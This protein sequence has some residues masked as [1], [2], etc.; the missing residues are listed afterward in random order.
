M[1]MLFKVCLLAAVCAPGWV[2]ADEPSLDPKSFA[3]IEAI[4]EH[5]AR[6]DPAS[7][8]RYKEQAKAVSQGA[9]E[10]ALVKLRKSSDY[11]TTHDSMLDLLSKSDEQNAKRVCARQLAIGG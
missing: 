1:K 5:C 10:E 8:D 4:L 2:L 11:V 7:A 3:S 9:S 6:T